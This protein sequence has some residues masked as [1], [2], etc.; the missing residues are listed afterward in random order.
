MVQV[1]GC[2][3]APSAHLTVQAAVAVV[4]ASLLDRP[5]PHPQPAMLAAA[6]IPRQA[7]RTI[8]RIRARTRR[9]RRRS[10]HLT[11]SA[12]PGIMTRLAYSWVGIK[13]SQRPRDGGYRGKAGI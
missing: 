3:T 10:I 1:P 12:S 6:L 7:C 4:A 8:L 9:V 11:R 13:L 5:A 2:L